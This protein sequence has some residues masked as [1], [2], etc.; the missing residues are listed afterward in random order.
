M[1]RTN[2]EFPR[3]GALVHSLL[4]SVH[5]LLQPRYAYYYST[6]IF[7]VY[8]SQ[9]EQIFAARATRRFELEIS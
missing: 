6:I 7:T 1:N 8:Y 2:V 3:P 4:H 5:S 9:T